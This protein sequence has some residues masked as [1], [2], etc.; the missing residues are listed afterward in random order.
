LAPIPSPGDAA[1][2][3]CERPTER[4]SEAAPDGAP[5]AGGARDTPTRR[6]RSHVC[7]VGTSAIRPTPR[8]QQVARKGGGH[9][10]D[11]L[12]T[13]NVL[14][15]RTHPLRKTTNTGCFRSG[16]VR[17]LRGKRNCELRG[18]RRGGKRQSGARWGGRV[19]FTSFPLPRPSS[20]RGWVVTRSMPACVGARWHVACDG[21]WA[22]AYA[23]R[24]PFAGGLCGGVPHSHGHAHG[25]RCVW[26]PPLL[27]ASS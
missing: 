5:A 24:R 25:A 26:I 1:R 27:F 3:D 21:P 10:S 15:R 11:V 16:Q 9:E 6:W 2:L 19:G 7:A 23:G 17:G 14:S 12:S 4:S 8:S 13:G 20:Y 18:R 22:G